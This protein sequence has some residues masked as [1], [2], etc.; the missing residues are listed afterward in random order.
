M[1]KNTICEII[2]PMSGINNKLDTGGKNT[3]VNKQKHREKKK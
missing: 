1:H 2:P 3:L